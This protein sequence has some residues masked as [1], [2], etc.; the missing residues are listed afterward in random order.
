M[1]ADPTS[2]E[3][4]SRAEHELR[5]RKSTTWWITMFL[6]RFG[7]L[8]ILYAAFYMLFSILLEPARGYFFTSSERTLPPILWFLIGTGMII[9]GAYI[10]FQALGSIIE[11]I[12]S[13]L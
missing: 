9:S 4:W 12:K 5:V 7:I 10:R 2:D 11:R 6:L 3:F 13:D 1:S 8:A